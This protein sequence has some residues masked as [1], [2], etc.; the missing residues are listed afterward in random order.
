MSQVVHPPIYQQCTRTICI[1]KQ[2]TKDYYFTI[3]PAEFL[4]RDETVTVVAV[5]RPR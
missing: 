5:L 2:L 4:K 3:E 1:V